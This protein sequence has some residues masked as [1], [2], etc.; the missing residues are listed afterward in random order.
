[1]EPPSE[2]IPE[3]SQNTRSKEPMQPNVHSSAIYNGQDLEIA[4]CPSVD[5]IKKLW[6]V[7]TV[8]YYVAK[9]GLPT[10]CDNIDGPGDYYAK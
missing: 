10:F 9:E 7:Y 2:N 6:Y 1:M 8:E 3:E 5:E 4:K